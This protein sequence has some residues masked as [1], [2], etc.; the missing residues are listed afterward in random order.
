MIVSLPFLYLV[1]LSLRVT[2]A[3]EQINLSNVAYQLFCFM[4]TGVLLTSSVLLSTSV[5]LDL[6]DTHLSTS[7][8]LYF[9]YGSM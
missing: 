9:L 6:M 7:V 1:D 4:T 2:L 3:Y 5:A 8:T